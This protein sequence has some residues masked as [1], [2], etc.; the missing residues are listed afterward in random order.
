MSMFVTGRFI[1]LQNAIITKWTIP[2]TASFGLQTS[3]AGTQGE[4]SFFLALNDSGSSIFQVNT[5]DA[6][7]EINQFYALAIIYDG[8]AVV[9]ERVKVYC[10]DEPVTLQV[11]GS[12][13]APV[14]LLD[15][16]APV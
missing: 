9:A 14:S 13:N 5:V 4:F 16:D 3:A 15:S 8:T 6:N 1:N 10:N 7:V 2:V 11:I 12:N